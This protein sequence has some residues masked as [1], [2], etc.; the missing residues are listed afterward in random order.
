MRIKYF[1]ISLSSFVQKDIDILKSKYEVDLF[2][3][4]VSNKFSLFFQLI[5]QLKFILFD[6]KKNEI[7]ISQFGGFHTFI[8]SVFSKILQQ[9]KS[10]IILG[11]TDCVSFPSIKYGNFNR[12]FLGFFTKI[13]YKYASLLLPVDET[14]IFCN[15]TYQD[16]DYKTQGYKAFIKKINTPVETIYNGYDFSLFSFDLIDKREPNSFVTI[17]ANLGSRFGQKLKG[18]DLIL[19]LSLKIPEAKFYIIG[20]EFLNVKNTPPNVILLPYID[21]NKL[22]HFLKT[23]EYY[24]QLSINEGFPNA[25]CEA[26]LCGCIPIVS[27]VGAM[28]K[29]VGYDDKFILKKKDAN[30]L[31][32]LIQKLNEKSEKINLENIR[33]KIT[34]N[35]SL[36]RRKKEILNVIDKMKEALN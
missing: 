11:G 32:D 25:L 28:P 26:M 36:D 8:P 33:K 9:K 24:L 30:L 5:K 21:N 29:I 2:H 15:Y 35:Y 19:E 27:N 3:F 6:I 34:S 1:Y 13:S 23:K 7:Y 20:G 22:P 12:K 17:G 10:I 14:L 18:I 4:N 31:F 16:D